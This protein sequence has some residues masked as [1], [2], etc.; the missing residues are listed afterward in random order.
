MKKGLSVWSCPVGWNLE[1]IFSAAAQA[2]FDGVEVALDERG[3]L[4]LSTTKEEMQKIRAVAQA[5][6]VALYSV[7]TGLYWQYSLTADSP[8]VREKAMDIVKK[9]IE[10]AACLGCE[11]VLVV[12]GAVGV[13]FAPECGVVPYDIAYQRAHE[14]ILALAPCA[15][16]AGVAIA[17]ENVWNKFLLSPL[18]L[19][20][21]IDSIGS[22]FVGAYFDVGNVLVNGYPE[23]WIDILG[24]RIKKVHIKDFQRAVGTLD[25]FC[26]LLAGDVDFPVVMSSL[27]RAGYDGWVTAEVGVM[28]HYP[29]AGLEHTAN[30][31]NYIIRG[32]N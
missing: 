1:Q 13:D 20:N 9:Q 2:G 19:R 12:P 18:E 25:G 26:P 16:A 6:G 32:G 3:E 7:A 21:F 27:R 22:D 10:T 8:Q 30:A 24:N 31:M 4:S 29:K 14:A 5:H 11:T 28:S 23:H 17:L 15:E